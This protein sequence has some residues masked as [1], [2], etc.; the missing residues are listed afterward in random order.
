MFLE[1]AHALPLKAE[2][3]KKVFARIGTSSYAGTNAES[4]GVNAV[5]FHKNL[6]QIDTCTDEALGSIYLMLAS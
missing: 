4:M 1:D 2:E 5:R 6:V 3:K